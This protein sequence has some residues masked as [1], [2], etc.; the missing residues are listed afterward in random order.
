MTLSRQ[1]VFKKIGDDFTFTFLE[2]HHGFIWIGGSNSLLR[3]D[4]YQITKYD[5]VDD[6]GSI[7]NPGWVP[8]LLEDHQQR[9]WVGTFNGLYRYDRSSD[10]FVQYFHEQ[11]KATKFRAGSIHSLYQD[12]KHRIWIGD[13]EHLYVL[14]NPDDGMIRF[15]DDIDVGPR[16]QAL[17]GITAIAEGPDGEIYAASNKGLWEVQSGRPSFC[18]LPTNHLSDPDKFSILDLAV[19]QNNNLWLATSEGIWIFNTDRKTFTSFQLPVLIDPVI[20]TLF[21]DK[22][23]SLWFG[24]ASNGLFHFKEG[25]F[26]NFPHDPDNNHTVMSNNIHAVMVDRFQN[27]WAGTMF[28]LSRANLKAQKFPFY[29]IDPGPNNYDNYVYRL[30]QDDSG[31]FWFR[32]LRLGLGYSPGLEGA[33]EILLNPERTSAIEEIKDFTQDVDG[34]VWVITLTHGLFKFSPVSRTLQPIDLGETIKQAVP[35]RIISDQIDPR[36]LWISTGQGLCRVNRLTQT[37]KWFSF[38]E[39]LGTQGSR[40]GQIEQAGNGDIWMSILYQKGSRLAYFDPV[41]EKFIAEFDNPAHPSS[42]TGFRGNRLKKINDRELWVSCAKGTI[43]INTENKTFKHVPSDFPIKNIYSIIPDLR[44]DLWFTGDENKI[45][46]YDGT[47]WECYSGQKDIQSFTDGGT[48]SKEGRITF[49]GTNGIYSFFPEEITFEKDSLRPKV[50]LTNFNVLNEKRHLKTAYE[51]VKNIELP[52]EENALSFEF[53]SLHYRRTEEIN[54]RY[55]LLGYQNY[56]VTVDG[57]ERTA[58]FTNL[59]PGNYTFEVEAETADSLVSNQEERLLINLRIA[60][61]WYRTGWA[62]ATYIGLLVFLLY[63][64]RNY[65]LRRQIARSEARQLK[66]LDSFKSRFYTNI[67]HEFRTPITLIEGMANQILRQPDHKLEE[68]ITLIKQNNQRLSQLVE[69]LLDLSK[70]ES[71]TL[72]LYP[73]QADVITYLHKISQPF[74]FYAEEKGI[75]LIFRSRP[76]QLQMDYDPDKLMDVVSNLLGNAIKFTPEGG[77]VYFSL[78]TVFKD[79]GEHLLISIRDTGIGI[80]QKNLP[81][82]FDRFYQVDTSSTRKGEGA[83]IGLALTRELVRLMHG[84]ITVESEI[85]RGTLFKVVLPIIREAPLG[86]SGTA[87]ITRPDLPSGANVQPVMPESQSGP[88]DKPSLLIVEDTPDVIYYLTQLLAD[89]YQILTAVNGQEGIDLAIT[90][91]PDI[92][93]SDVMMPEKDGF[94]LCATLKEDPRTSH[95]PIILLTARAD[96]E[97]RITGLQRGAD[98]YL[99]KPFIKAELMTRLQKLIE[100]RARLQARYAATGT[101]TPLPEPEFEIEDEFI[102]KVRSKVEARLDDDSLTIA[103]LAEQ[104]EMNRV[105]LFRK[106]KALTGQSPSR[107]VRSIRLG[108]AQRM[109]LETQL[110][111]AE[112]AYKVGFS[113][114]A[115]FSRTFREAYGQ[116]PSEFRQG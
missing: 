51:L 45:C 2:D 50:V 27:I 115:F 29:Q 71:G 62:Y 10:R 23:Q 78:N 3:Y 32:L 57:D 26:T 93:I 13:E 73:V 54:Y 21:I 65:D 18:R 49:G 107:L 111:V 100:L 89:Q 86:N 16:Y 5:M 101:E 14:E 80:E 38:E 30:M 75:D 47:I 63:T 55:R 20:T 98:A 60:P 37:A 69:Q 103:Q 68:G 88:V 95:I 17:T 43:I 109:L 41:K 7:I 61:P 22:D 105:Q 116:S 106:I 9:L 48:L 28:G 108:H 76:E 19:G 90:S 39:D 92:I 112:I 72:Q 4:G 25:V 44:G 1:Y 79:R 53:T 35:L 102:Q 24:T 52:Y 84:E 70:L 104:L 85:N 114:P 83:G 87:N 46:K 77:S 40:I 56:W 67:T 66:E 110:T 12:R 42:V 99:A 74:R 97:A 91:V 15:I 82:V 11:Q 64:F 96:A 6:T 59:D 58:P 31:G 8:A 94:E 36:L 33:C 113:D 81:F 34:N